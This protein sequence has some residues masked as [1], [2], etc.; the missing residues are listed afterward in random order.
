VLISICLMIQPMS[1]DMY[2]ASFPGLASVFNVSPAT[3]Q[4]TLSAFVIGFGCAQLMMGPLSDRFGRRLVLLSGLALYFLSSLVCTL[5]PSIETL[6]AAR[7]FQAVGCSAVAIVARAV[8]RDAYAPEHGMQIMVRAT[9]W[10]AFTPVLAPVIG[11]YLEVWFG[12]RGSFAM[13]STVSLLLFTAVFLRLPETNQ[14][15]NP[16]AT[17]LAGLMKNYRHILG[18]RMFWAYASIG[19]FSFGSIFTFI[20]GASMI[21]IHVLH[22]P[23]TWFGYSFSFGTLGYLLGTIA[24]RQMLRRIGT[25]RTL[26]ISTRIFLLCGGIFLGLVLIRFWHWSVML[27]IMFATMFLH[28][29]Q[30]PL[31]QAGAITPFAEQAGTAAGLSGTLYMIMAFIIITI[32]GVAYNGTMYPIAIIS[33]ITS[34]L[35]F[36]CV[37]IFPELKVVKNKPA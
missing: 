34:A 31:S 21:L 36:I 22:M 15:K 27:G 32:M 7:F 24:C 30:S 14:N 1:T 3:V 6:I 29:I 12:W 16:N 2:T 9:T 20:S 17:N 35:A 8:I 10:L 19:A 18:S 5:S 23:V 4:L 13:H 26:R 37:R 25:N 11:A 28:G 33:C